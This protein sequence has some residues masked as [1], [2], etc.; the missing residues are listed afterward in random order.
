[1][2]N[3]T[4]TL[5]GLMLARACAPSVPRA[6]LLMM[7]AANAPD[8]DVVSGAFGA[9]AYLDYHRWLTHGVLLSP[10]MALGPVLLVWFLSRSTPFPWLRSWAWSLLAVLSHLLLDWTN[11]YGIRLLA[12]FS[13]RWFRLDTTHVI[14]P[15]ILAVLILAVAAPL[16]AR[17]VGSEIGGGNKQGPERG[18]ALFALLFVVFYDGGRLITHAR[19]VAQLSSRIYAGGVADRVTALPHALNPLRWT[20]VV[21]K[22]DF[23]V[24]LPVDLRTEFDPVSGRTFYRAGEASGWARKMGEADPTFQSL[25]RFSQIPFW[26]VVPLSDPDGSVRVELSDLRFGTPPDPGF[27]AAGTATPGG[28]LRGVTLSF[29]SVTK[30]FR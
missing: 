9:A 29:G 25:A 27:V 30:A 28:S 5:T 8:L 3:V 22:T 12:P 2:D 18:W 4:H 7:L 23:V 1:M 16:L 6:G 17:L 21:E 20:G 10:L 24:I 14:D 26:R 11:V 13:G 19:A 15:W